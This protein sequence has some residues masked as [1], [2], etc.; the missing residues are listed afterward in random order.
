MQNGVATFEADETY[1][2]C[3]LV[4]LPKGTGVSA[5]TDNPL[6][7]LNEDYQKSEV[8]DLTKD[9]TRNPFRDA[10][11]LSAQTSPAI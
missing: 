8:I 4:S 6:N 7:I 10:M 1:T 3:V 2:K 9:S 11:N 5:Y